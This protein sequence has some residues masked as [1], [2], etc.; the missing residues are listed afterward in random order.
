MSTNELSAIDW[1]SDEYRV[2]ES[3][4]I[5]LSS[6]DI[7][8]RAELIRMAMKSYEAAQESPHYVYCF[9]F[10]GG[11][12]WYVGETA[13]LVNRISTHIRERG[14]TNIERVETVENREQGLERE[15]E[16]SYEIAIDKG[17]TE[18]YGGR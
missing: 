15:R 9:S 7:S 4:T 3:S 1:D 5:D 18:I 16:L 11:D 10:D 2:T 17:S 12:R 14:I 8:N 13:N 6:D